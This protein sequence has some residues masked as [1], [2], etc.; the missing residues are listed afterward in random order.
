MVI[1]MCL[2]KHTRSITFHDFPLKLAWVPAILPT[3]FSQL[4]IVHAFA[5]LSLARTGLRETVL[6]LGKNDKGNRPA[7][8]RQV[9]PCQ[10]KQVSVQLRTKSR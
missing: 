7:I 1:M 6:A 4:H 5:W 2:L 3:W 9:A 10:G 8:E